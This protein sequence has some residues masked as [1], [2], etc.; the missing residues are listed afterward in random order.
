MASTAWTAASALATRTT[1]TMPTSVMKARI[2]CEVIAFT[3]SRDTVGERTMLHGLIETKCVVP[4]H[5]VK[6]HAGKRTTGKDPEK[7]AADF[8]TE[9]VPVPA[10]RRGRNV[11]GARLGDQGVS[12]GCAGIRPGRRF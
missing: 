1:G 12:A 2:S 9:F 10:V 8:V 7:R 5:I 11:G 6:S 3:L 4:R